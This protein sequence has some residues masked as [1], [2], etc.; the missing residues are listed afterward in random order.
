MSGIA[1]DLV[2]E[3][4]RHALIAQARVTSAD[5]LSAGSAMA[6]AY[7]DGARTHAHVA[8]ALAAVAQAKRA[9]S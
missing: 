4:E 9:T 6:K 3:A 5:E 8:L 2:R 1:D 7:R